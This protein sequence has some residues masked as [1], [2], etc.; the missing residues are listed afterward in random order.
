MRSANALDELRKHG[1]RLEVPVRTSRFHVPQRP[2]PKTSCSLVGR[3]E[4]YRPLLCQA[5]RRNLT[6]MAQVAQDR[7]L[8][9]PEV[10][11]LKEGSN[12]CEKFWHL[13]RF[14]FTHHTT[15]ATYYMSQFLQ[16][17]PFCNV[18]THIA[19][20]HSHPKDVVR[21]RMPNS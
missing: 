18:S 10:F 3:F 2:A 9:D 6:L 12:I 21:G 14:T 7:T 11:V 19:L 15:R 17:G 20:W 16:M 13:L 4:L 1:W 8:H 5:K